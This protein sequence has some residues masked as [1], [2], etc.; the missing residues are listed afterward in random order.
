METKEGRKEGRTVAMTNAL[1][2]SRTDKCGVMHGTA[3]RHRE[4]GLYLSNGYWPSTW[5]RNVLK[6]CPWVQS[7]SEATYQLFDKDN[8]LL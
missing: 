4:R 8:P 5:G 3:A 1:S 7:N 2:A 6:V